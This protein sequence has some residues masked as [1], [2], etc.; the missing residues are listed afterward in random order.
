MIKT[1]PAD[2]AWAVFSVLILSLLF[3]AYF[4]LR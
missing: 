4:F 3:W 2:L 1:Q